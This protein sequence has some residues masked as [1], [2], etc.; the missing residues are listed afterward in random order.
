MSVFD[1]CLTVE[2]YHSSGGSF[3]AFHFK[4]PVAMFDQSMWGFGG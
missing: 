4:G 3:L 1:F 2:G